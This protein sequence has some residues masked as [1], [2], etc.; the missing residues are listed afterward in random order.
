[1]STKELAIDSLK[2]LPETATWE[3]IQE[4]IRFM[5]AIEK[6]RQDMREG[7]LVAHESIQHELRQ[8]ISH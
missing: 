7:R 2:A 1:M 4:R 8:W 6:G 3:E 5:A